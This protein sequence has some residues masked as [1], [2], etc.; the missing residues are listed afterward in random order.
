MGISFVRSRVGNVPV[1]PFGVSG[2]RYGDDR[3]FFRDGSPLVTGPN[4][5]F[6]SRPLVEVGWGRLGVRL[7]TAGHHLKTSR[8]ARLQS[9]HFGRPFPVVPRILH[10]QVSDV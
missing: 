9:L 6:G 7:R 4:L 10:R 2:P 8:I 5:G 3:D 1:T